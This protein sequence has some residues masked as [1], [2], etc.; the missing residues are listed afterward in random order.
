[1]FSFDREGKEKNKLL[2]RV[3]Q[4]NFTSLR[5]ARLDDMLDS[6]GLDHDKLCTYCWNGVE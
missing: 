3:K 5:Y 4:K 6:T 1:M 2:M